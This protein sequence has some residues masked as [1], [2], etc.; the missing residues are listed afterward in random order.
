[1]KY[2]V[3]WGN[4]EPE[5]YDG[6][7]EWDALRN[8]AKENLTYSQ[9]RVFDIVIENVKDFEECVCSFNALSV[10]GEIAKMYEIGKVLYEWSDGDERDV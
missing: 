8:V 3:D 6:E 10:H 2:L 4:L 1:M 5:I 7:D 9:N